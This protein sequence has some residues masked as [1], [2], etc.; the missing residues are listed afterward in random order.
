MGES[1][2]HKLKCV[3]AAVMGDSPFETVAMDDA[4]FDRLL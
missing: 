2:F 1:P 4:T 3:M